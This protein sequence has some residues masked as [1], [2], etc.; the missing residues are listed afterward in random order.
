MPIDTEKFARVH[1]LD[2]KGRANGRHNIPSAT[3]GAFDANEQDIVQRVISEWTWHSGELLNQLRAYATRLVGYSVESEFQRLRLIGNNALASLRSAHHT[4]N[5]ELGHLRNAYGDARNEYFNFRRMHGLERPARNQAGRWTTFGLLVLLAAF[6]S[7]LNGFFFAKGSEF[8]LVGGIG[9]A[10]GISITNVSFAFLVGLGPARWINHKNAFLKIIGVLLVLAIMGALIVFH[11]FAAHLRDATAAFG[12]SRA[13]TIAIESIRQ[14]PWKLSELSSYYLFGLGTLFAFS[15]MWKGYS[16]DDPY[17]TYGSYSRRFAAARQAYDDEHCAIFDDLDEIK[18]GVVNALDAGIHRMPLFPQEA[19]KIR[20][21]RTALIET[22]RQYESGIEAATNQLLARYR[23][24]NLSTR[25]E[26]APP[27]FRTLWQ[28]TNRA[29]EEPKVIAI[30]VDPTSTDYSLDEALKQLG[31][32]S[33]NILD[34]YETL[35]TK[36]P[37]SQEIA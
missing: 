16:F 22:F 32:L 8:G 25:L 30:L 7:I 34:E 19:A 33:K 26:P 18:E 15:A 3:S 17:P 21:Q 29:L 10:V 1:D 11:V 24:A 2:E 20:A 23:E 36:Y 28:F 13:M 4:A 14:T 6:E 31:H 37:H 27:H 12:E 9:T 5:A 35:I